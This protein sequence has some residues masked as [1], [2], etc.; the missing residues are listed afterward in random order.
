M[1]SWSKIFR[2]RWFTKNLIER[3]SK[4]RGAILAIGTPFADLMVWF[5]PS[6]F[7]GGKSC[8]RL[9]D[10]DLTLNFRLEIRRDFFSAVA[11]DQLVRRIGY[12]M[13]IEEFHVHFD[14]RI[15]LSTLIQ[16]TFWQSMFEESSCPP[17]KGWIS[18]A[19]VRGYWC[20]WWFQLWRSWTTT[21]FNTL[22]LQ[23]NS[24]LLKFNL[25]L[26]FRIG[27]YLKDGRLVLAH[28]LI[29]PG[30]VL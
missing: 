7:V 14:S 10:I 26:T 11:S 23:R 19:L 1:W 27:W 29:F 3:L 13:L 22:Q 17:W 30:W 8:S 15:F 2:E 24:G 18:I 16:G 6:N 28:H 9:L 20:F 4:D 21:N 12:L 5:G 25:Y